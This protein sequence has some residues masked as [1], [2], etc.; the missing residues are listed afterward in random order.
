MTSVI[1]ASGEHLL[2]DFYGVAAELLKDALFLER[3]LREAAEQAGARVLSSHFHRFGEEEGVTG[4]VL[5]SESHLS[6]HTWPESG[7]AALDVFMCGTAR[8]QRA[9]DHA[10]S[11]LKPSRRRVTHAARGAR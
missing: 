11:V 10:A 8:P 5:L 9:L 3:L 4:V 7:F 1:S 6:I 2:A